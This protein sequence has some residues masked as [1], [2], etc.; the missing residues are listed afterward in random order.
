M[1]FQGHRFI[2]LEVCEGYTHILKFQ[3]GGCF[4]SEKS[5]SSKNTELT[6]RFKVPDVSWILE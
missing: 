3:K 4:F 1:L 5:I 2:I 6:V